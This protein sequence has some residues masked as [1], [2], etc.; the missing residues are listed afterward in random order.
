MKDKYG[1]EIDYMRISITDRCNYR[2]FYCMPNGIESLDYNNLSTE[3]ILGVVRAGAKLGIKKV[4]I[5][6][7]EPLIRGDI[8]EILVGISRVD[9]IE[10]LCIT[11]NGS[12]LLKKADLLKNSGVTRINVS[13]D[14]LIPSRFKEITGRDEYY[15]VWQGIEKILEYGIEVRLNSVVVV[16]VNDDEVENLAR[17][18]KKYPIDV[19][20]IELMP[21]GEGKRYK[22]MNGQEIKELLSRKESLEDLQKREGAS[23]YYRYLGALGRIGFINP[24]SNCFCSDCNRIRVDAT[25]NIKQCINKEPKVNIANIGAKQDRNEKI[26]EVIKGE[27]YNKP[28]KHL[29]NRENDEEEMKNMNQIGG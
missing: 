13:L 26:L 28:E 11:T 24:M 9:G 12:L 27:I 20:F 18:T 19:R 8:E 14:T 17:L 29:F 6:G 7:G 21:I 22:G 5:T 4:R 15:R 16:G 2:C 3:D 25:G 23:E 1:R 10:E